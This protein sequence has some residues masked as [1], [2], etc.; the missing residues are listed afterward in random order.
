MQVARRAFLGTWL[1]ALA[2]ASVR[3]QEWGPPTLAAGDPAAPSWPSR[4]RFALWPGSLPGRPS[5]P[6]VAN[7]TMN[8]PQGGRMLFVRG[9]PFPEV[10]V[11]RPSRPDGSAMLSIPG[12]GY[13][14]VSVQN[15][16]LDVAHRFNPEGMTVFVLTYRLPGEG[17]P[18]RDRVA[19]QDAQRA[20]RLIRSRAAEF[21][22][23]PAR[24]GVVGFSAGGHLA[25]DLAVSFG[26][27][28]YA[29]VDAA[30]RLSARPA[31]AGLIYPIVSLTPPDS[32][33]GAIE[34][35]T[36]PNPPAAIVAARSPLLKVRKD[37]PPSFLAHAADDPVVPVEH[38]IRWLTACRAAGAKCEAH[39]FAEGNH[40]FGLG[41]PDN[42]PGSRWPELFALWL[43]KNGG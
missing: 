43:R 29:P 19:I 25:A 26:E 18:N 5:K 23:D 4:E 6:I 28:F 12:G 39:I 31:Y 40:G 20:M 37:I 15:E 7:W 3:A 22:I 32:G 17:W 21:R 38:S 30:D 10:H 9:V 42:Q 2:A 33:T 27:P 41:L 34:K 1:A 11:F 36:G 14:F 35:L 16:G 8:G 24:L 13:D